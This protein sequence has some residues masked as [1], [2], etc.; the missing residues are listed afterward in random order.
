[1]QVEN[2]TPAPNHCVECNA[3][4]KMEEMYICED[5]FDYTV[6][7]TVKPQSEGS[8]LELTDAAYEE[9]YYS[10]QED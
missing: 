1:M 2:F 4:L 6:D 5:C 9:A 10:S 7:R 3:P 8:S